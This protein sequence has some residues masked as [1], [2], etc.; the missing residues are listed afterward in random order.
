MPL[1]AL[2]ECDPKMESQNFFS[3]KRVFASVTLIVFSLALISGC[4]GK[5]VTVYEAVPRPDAPWDAPTIQIDSPVLQN[6]KYSVYKD[7]NNSRRCYFVPGS[8]TIQLSAQAGLPHAIAWKRGNQVVIGLPFSYSAG[9]FADAANALKTIESSTTLE[10]LTFPEV[11]LKLL[12]PTGAQVL[13][14]IQIRFQAGDPKSEPFNGMLFL[15]TTK[16]SG[17][18][19]LK[20][21]LTIDPAIL[22]DYQISVSSVTH[23]DPVP[24][25]RQLSI[26]VQIG[27]LSLSQL[28]ATSQSNRSSINP[29]ITKE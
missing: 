7:A 21:L 13:D 14:D 25:S 11:R 20:Q 27:N 28:P 29:A 24:K 16:R 2:K 8:L 5:Y 26:S 15:A 12:G 17:T 3:T 10:P 4:R 23:A 6:A 1:F 19:V 22:L 18:K 9:A